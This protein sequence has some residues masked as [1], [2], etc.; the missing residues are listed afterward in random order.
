MSASRDTRMDRLRIAPDRPIASH[1][2]QPSAAANEDEDLAAIR[3]IVWQRNGRL[4]IENTSADGTTITIFLPHPKSDA[5][6]CQG[7]GGPVQATRRPERVLIVDDD[8]Q[9]RKFIA[10]AL[11]S[12]G[13]E[14]L[15]ARSGKEA[16][17]RCERDPS[18]I[19]LLIA[20]VVMP[21]MS[22][23]HLASQLVKLH[24]GMKV[25]LISGYPNLSGFLN[26]VVSRSESFKAECEFIQKPFSRD[27]LLEK[28]RATLA[29]SNVETPS[30]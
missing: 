1:T 20:D 28:V 7:T 6:D 12:A 19:H 23:P 25:L 29:S 8:E 4:Q 13:C 26:G 9:I 11:A 14:I 10:F 27:A 17:E 5:L 18:E 30:R 16:I 22:G 24:P 3:T 15:E 21:H 2:E